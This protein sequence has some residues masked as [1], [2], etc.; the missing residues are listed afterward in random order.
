MKKQGL[1]YDSDKLA[2]HLVPMHLLE[3]MVRV[4]MFGAKKY[5]SHNYSFRVRYVNTAT[6]MTDSMW[7][8]SL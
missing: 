2:L 6:R 8:Q 5:A 7:M 4:L 3:G 1:R